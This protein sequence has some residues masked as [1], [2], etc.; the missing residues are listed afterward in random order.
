VRRVMADDGE[1]RFALSSMTHAA[2]AVEPQ[3]TRLIIYTAARSGEVLLGVRCYGHATLS[4]RRWRA[5][6]GRA[7]GVARHSLAFLSSS[8]R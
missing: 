2:H 4:K 6:I 1:R 8:R 5:R 7:A 3:E